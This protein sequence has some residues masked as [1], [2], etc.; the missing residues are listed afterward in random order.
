MLQL[1]PQSDVLVPNTKNPRRAV[2]YI[3][4]YIDSVRCDSLSVDIS[5]MNLMDACYVST[6]CSTNHYIKYP[7]GRINWLVS[8]DKAAELTKSLS[9]GNSE[10]F[11]AN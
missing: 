9:L 10:Y 4:S 3:N 1:L 7:E 2:E 8:S 5:F 11:V 6:M